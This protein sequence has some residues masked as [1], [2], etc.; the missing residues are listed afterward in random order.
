M[1]RAHRKPLGKIWKD[2]EAQRFKGIHSTYLRACRVNRHDSLWG[3]L[4]PR[5]KPGSFVLS[6]AGS[7]M[8]SLANVRR[9]KRVQG[10]LAVSGLSFGAYGYEYTWIFLNVAVV[11]QYET[12][13]RFAPSSST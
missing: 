5:E 11:P 2:M 6:H 13:A 1:L 3:H 12:D 4:G 9:M 10:R 8:V 7:Y